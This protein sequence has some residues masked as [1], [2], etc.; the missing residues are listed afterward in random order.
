ML[1]T[2]LT[3]IAGLAWG[4]ELMIVFTPKVD[5]EELLLHLHLES[6]LCV[7]ARVILFFIFFTGHGSSGVDVWRAF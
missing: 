4:I 2:V 7:C 1:L 6:A 5:T 3:C